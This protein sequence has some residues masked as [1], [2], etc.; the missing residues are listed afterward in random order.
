MNTNDE[1]FLKW[2]Q[3]KYHA[4]IPEMPSIASDT[5]WENWMNEQKKEFKKYHPYAGVFVK[6]IRIDE[7]V[8]TINKL[9]K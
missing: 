9:R 7:F 3:K 2:L 1:I 5:W 6:N 4:G 8:E